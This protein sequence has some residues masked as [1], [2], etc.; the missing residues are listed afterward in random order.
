MPIVINKLTASIEGICTVEDAEPLLE[1]L[2]THP[3]GTVNLKDCENLHTS[4]LQ[5][6]LIGKAQMASSPVDLELSCWTDAVMPTIKIK[7]RNRKIPVKL[8][9]AQGK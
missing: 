2:I 7:K 6:L 1:W 3:G 8:E 5:V 4:V 9:E